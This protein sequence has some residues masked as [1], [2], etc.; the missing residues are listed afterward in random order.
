MAV[1]ELG[2]ESLGDHQ[3]HEE[4]PDGEAL[5]GYKLREPE[6]MWGVIRKFSRDFS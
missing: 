3:D 4:L 2:T 5:P 6:E 1:W